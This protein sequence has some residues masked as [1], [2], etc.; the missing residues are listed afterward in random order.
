MG[1]TLVLLVL[2]TTVLKCL[3][4]ASPL[5]YNFE[6]G[7]TF[8]IKSW[9]KRQMWCG[10]AALIEHEWS[11]WQAFLTVHVNKV[12]I[13]T[14][15][16]SR[17][18]SICVSAYTRPPRKA[19]SDDSLYG[20]LPEIPLTHHVLSSHTC[21]FLQLH[22]SLVCVL[23]LCPFLSFTKDLAIVCCALSSDTGHM[24]QQRVRCSIN[25]W[26]MNARLTLIIVTTKEKMSP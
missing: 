26:C 10:F 15:Y 17:I 5:N 11:C 8:S 24:A 6:K 16:Y 7:H 23:C 12:E 1:P 3:P 19:F 14:H 2:L 21:H 25:I 13:T 20:L 18:L 22:G 4:H 9:K